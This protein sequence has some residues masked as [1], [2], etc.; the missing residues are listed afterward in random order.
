ML[1]DTLVTQPPPIEVARD[2]ILHYLCYSCPHLGRW[3]SV[4]QSGC[5]IGREEELMG[6]LVLELQAQI[7]YEPRHTLGYNVHN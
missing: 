7:S 3:S 6:Y 2:R 5:Y 4:F 1:N